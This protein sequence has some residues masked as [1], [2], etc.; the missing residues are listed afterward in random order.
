MTFI[1]SRVNN[2]TIKQSP[3]VKSLE[4]KLKVKKLRSGHLS[5]LLVIEI[6][7]VLLYISSKAWGQYN[8][9][10]EERSDLSAE[11]VFHITGGNEAISSTWCWESPHL[12]HDCVIWHQLRPRQKWLKKTVWSASKIPELPCSAKSY[13]TKRFFLKCPAVAKDR[14]TVQVRPVSSYGCSVLI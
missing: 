7:A 6:Q 4:L 3:E 12:H 9:S 14:T 13:L 10:I 1:Q 11:K 8:N 2:A 5:L